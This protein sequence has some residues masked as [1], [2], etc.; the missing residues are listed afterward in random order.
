MS[1][2]WTCGSSSDDGAANDGLWEGRF[3]VS[4]DGAVAGYPPTRDARRPF[5]GLGNNRCKFLGSVDDVGGWCSPWDDDYAHT[6]WD[7]SMVSRFFGHAK[8]PSGWSRSSVESQVGMFPGIVESA[9]GEWLYLYMWGTAAT[10]HVQG[11]CPDM[12][13]NKC[14][15]LI[16]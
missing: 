11:H 3:L 15:P 7:T 14:V 8:L 9:D 2:T 13:G 16:R 1:L 10:H 12:W 5:V 6:S 4:S